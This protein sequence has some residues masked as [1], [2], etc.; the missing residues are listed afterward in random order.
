ME[1]SVIFDLYASYRN[2]AEQLAGGRILRSEREQL[3]RVQRSSGT[4]GRD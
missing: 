3:L 1:R 2:K 4:K